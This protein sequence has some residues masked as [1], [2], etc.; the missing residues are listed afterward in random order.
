MDVENFAGRC[1]RL[2]GGP[3]PQHVTCV[4]KFPCL[5]SLPEI[6]T[7]TLTLAPDRLYP[8]NGISP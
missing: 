4:P 5:P 6:S 1:G 7:F 2:I 3:Q 8:A